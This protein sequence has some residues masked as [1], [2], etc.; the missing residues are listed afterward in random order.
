[1]HA[2]LTPFAFQPF[3]LP[4]VCGHQLRWRA[5]IPPDLGTARQ[6]EY[7]GLRSCWGRLLRRVLGLSPPDSTGVF[8]LQAGRSVVLPQ[9]FSLGRACLR[10]G[11]LQ[12]PEGLGFRDRLEVTVWA[13][14]GFR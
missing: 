9:L 14:K 2:V 7:D 11:D 4:V 12:A 3:C 6:Q 13:D 5:V 8:P 10:A 1:M